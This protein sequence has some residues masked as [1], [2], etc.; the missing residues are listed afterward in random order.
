[1]EASF[2]PCNPM[3]DYH[4]PVKERK[5][6]GNGGGGGTKKPSA[7][8][9][10]AKAATKL[11]TDRQSVAARERRHRISDRF[12]ILQS[13]VPGGTK[14]DTVSMLE[15]A[16]HYV[17]FL[18]AQIWLHE[19]M[20]NSVCDQSNHS[21]SNSN[22]SSNSSNIATSINNNNE[23][24]PGNV[25]VDHYQLMA[26]NGLPAVVDDEWLH[27]HSSAAGVPQAQRGVFVEAGGA[28]DCGGAP[29]QEVVESMFYDDDDDE[30]MYNYP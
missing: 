3:A 12:K 8:G 23:Y 27:A 18:K 22:S 2:S 10:G 17:N 15:G 11:S 26:E 30:L 16:I 9:G 20:I 7:A 5:R 28:V 19:A 14:M 25:V 21:N 29:F 13:L 1:M 24:Y 6:H 4:Q